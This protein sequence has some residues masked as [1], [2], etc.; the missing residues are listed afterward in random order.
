MKLLIS[1]V[2]SD[3]WTIK[4]NDKKVIPELFADAL[5]I[6]P[7]EKGINH[8]SAY[9]TLPGL[10]LG[11]TVSVIGLMLMIAGEIILNKKHNNNY[12]LDNRLKLKEEVSN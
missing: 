5:M 11:I 7:L 1:F 3:G 10:K 4:V 12:V 9:Y 8:V 6:V 2:D